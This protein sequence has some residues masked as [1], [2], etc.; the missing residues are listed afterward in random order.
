[1]NDLETVIFV[2]TT[3]VVLGLGL[4]VGKWL[5]PF[6]RAKLFRSLT[7]KE[8]GILALLSPDV[9][10]IRMIVVNFGKDVIQ[11]QGK[12]WIALKDRIY[13][14]DKPERGFRLDKPDLPLKWISGIPVIFVNE[15]SYSPIEI[16]GAVGEV[17][18]DEVNSVFSSWINNQLAKSAAKILSA[19]S[20]QQ[21]LLTIIAVLCLVAAGLGFMAYQEVNNVKSEV[22]GVKAE[23][24][25]H[26]LRTTGSS[27]VPG[28]PGR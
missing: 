20:K 23:L 4:F 15:T 14:M 9:K 18:P 22:I 13:R 7:K 17:R 24:H 26:V 3:L 21:T 6:F 16:T 19:F 27:T 25:D 1:M 5:D 28:T 12:V 10:T 2:I 8:Y 11:N